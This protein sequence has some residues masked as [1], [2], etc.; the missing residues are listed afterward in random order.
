[1]RP[2]PRSL[3][4]L[5]DETLVGFILRLARH[6]GTPPDHIASRLGLMDAQG[7]S[8]GVVSPWLL[9]D[10]DK[11]RL[12]RVARAAHL[13]VAEADKL[14]LAPMGR[15]YG[16]VGRRYRP[17]TSPRQLDR[18]NR[19]VFVRTSQY[20]PSCLAGDGGPQE[21]LSGGAW[22]RSWQ[23]PAVFAC[24]RHQQL[25]HRVCPACRTP[26]QFARAGLIAR[27]GT[28][29][30][31]PAQ[32]RSSSASGPGGGRSVVCGADLSRIRP[33]RTSDVADSL[34]TLL[35]LQER[36]DALLTTDGSQGTM[37]CGQLVPVAQYFIDLRVVATSPPRLL[38]GGRPLYRDIRLGTADRTRGRAATA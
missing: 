5:D 36:L 28:G 13:I 19:W 15:R 14:L 38:A 6:N 3:D 22:R 27:P 7:E 4:P 18:A 31:H 8:P 37:S 1:M 34:K 30:L 33:A 10:M 25:L 9:V 23:L 29:D 21:A 12:V 2:L 11:P 32:C 24:V 35:A 20:C 26:G 16:L 17:W